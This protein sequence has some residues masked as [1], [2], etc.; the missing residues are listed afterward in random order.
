MITL[1]LYFLFFSPTKNTNPY[2]Y[3][4]IRKHESFGMNLPFM[5]VADIIFTYCCYFYFT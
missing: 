5:I 4:N 1:L 2:E 3:N